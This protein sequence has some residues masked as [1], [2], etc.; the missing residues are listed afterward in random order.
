MRVRKNLKFNLP[1][2]VAGSLKGEYNMAEQ[3]V[4]KSDPL[5][6]VEA[7]T[8]DA[9]LL[10]TVEG[11]MSNLRNILDEQE[12]A[13]PEPEP[14]P[15]I[16]EPEPEPEPEPAED[17]EPEPE[18]TPEPEEDEEKGSKGKEDPPE[19]VDIPEGY[20]RAAKGQ[21]WTDE[22]IADEIEAN[23]ERARRLFQNAYET[24]NKATRDF[25]AIGREKAERIRLEAEEKVRVETPEPKD[26]ITVDEIAKIADGD[27]ATATVLRAM[28]ARIK[29]DATALAKPQ[30]SGPSANDLEFARSDQQVATARANAT[31][32]ANSLQTVN[33]FFS[34]D[35]MKAYVEFY[36][37]IK[38]GQDWGDIT[39]RQYDHRM[40]VLQIA[41]QLKAGK[42]SQNIQVTDAEALS[43]AH[44]LVTDSMRESMVADK[45]K[46]TLKKRTKTLRPSDSRKTKAS[47]DTTKA[48]TRE[49]AIAN[50]ET[51]LAKFNKSWNN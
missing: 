17:S 6:D 19:A 26:F 18:P 8:E 1:L 38:Q 23:P 35:D 40:E 44:L 47:G 9:D 25:A 2:L 28:N 13:E 31:A 21:G 7:A 36:G 24:S 49:Q 5:K 34:A 11:R 12:P 46:K 37:V 50:A 29:A 39:P 48:K 33:Q 42:A 4:H 30:K 41:D 32:E 20:V 27:E 22:D 16:P 45:I 15:S 51:R 43:N 3:K 14:E 10:G